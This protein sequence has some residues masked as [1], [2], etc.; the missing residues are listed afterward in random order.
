MPSFSMA[1]SRQIPLV[2]RVVSERCE[3]EPRADVKLCGFRSVQAN[4]GPERKPPTR[5]VVKANLRLEITVHGL[6]V[7][8]T[9]ETTALLLKRTW[10]LRTEMGG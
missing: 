5:A 4:V 10:T 6:T 7:I 9:Y 3:L 1:A 8:E 2:K